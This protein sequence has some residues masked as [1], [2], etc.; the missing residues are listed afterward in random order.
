MF[1]SVDSSEIKITSTP[2]AATAML[3]FYMLDF[4]FHHS[5]PSGSEDQL[6]N[7]HILSFSLCENI[8]IH[9]YTRTLTI[10]I[11][12]F[13]LNYGMNARGVFTNQLSWKSLGH[14]SHVRD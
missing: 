14:R 11:Y 13:I 3:I 8:Q 2:A 1:D 9:I 7:K 4:R 12:L 6:I 10:I 5:S